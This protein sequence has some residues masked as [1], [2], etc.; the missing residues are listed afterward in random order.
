M[1][2]I[3][4]IKITLNATAGRKIPYALGEGNNRVDAIESDMKGK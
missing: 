2:E 3:G 4:N 1:D